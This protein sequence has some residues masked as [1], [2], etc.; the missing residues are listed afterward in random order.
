MFWREVHDKKYWIN[1]KYF[2]HPRR[3]KS[4][5][6]MRVYIINHEHCYTIFHDF[7]F[8]IASATLSEAR[9]VGQ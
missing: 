5:T 7:G 4:K 8:V 3:W 1:H 9:V 2:I 6:E